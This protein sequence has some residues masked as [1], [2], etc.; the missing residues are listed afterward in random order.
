[1]RRLVVAPDAAVGEA[2][3]GRRADHRADQGD[4]AGLDAQPGDAA[5]R[6]P[7]PERAVLAADQR[8][9]SREQVE[10]DAEAVGPRAPLL[11]AE[12]AHPGDHQRE[13]AE[14]QRGQRRG[15]VTVEVDELEPREADDPGDRGPHSDAGRVGQ[16]SRQAAAADQ[17][18]ARAQQPGEGSPRV[19]RREHVAEQHAG[20]G[21]PD[22]EDHVDERD[23]EVRVG[24]LGTVEAAVDDE[25]ER[26]KADRTGQPVQQPRQPQQ[27]SAV[28]VLQLRH[29]P[30]RRE[31]DER[32]DEHDRGR[33]AEQPDGDRQIGLADDAVRIGALRHGQRHDQQPAEQHRQ[34]ATGRGAHRVRSLWNGGDPARRL[35]APLAY[36]GACMTPLPLASSDTLTAAIQIGPLVL[37]ALLY[38]R[39]VRTL[40]VSGQTGAR[41]APGVLLLGLRRDRRRAHLAR[42]GQPGAAVRAHDRAPAARRHRLAADRAR[43]DRAA[44]RAD[45][46]NQAVRPPAGARPTL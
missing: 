7:Q 20:D 37:A 6:P 41:L 11:D 10:V 2:V 16:R 29:A 30:Q 44:D 33:P 15:P 13:V 12:R 4:R 25:R 39:R 34:L 9:E 17:P 1:M 5:Q 46:Q 40:A 35:P 38:T 24:F 32:D 28:F 43:A 45:P 18:S 22:P 8:R 42:P 3:E 27:P 21:Q 23:G 36:P 14:R 19:Q 26:R 31:R